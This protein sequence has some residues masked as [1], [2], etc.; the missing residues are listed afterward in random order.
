MLNN[1]DIQLKEKNNTK[2]NFKSVFE[3]SFINF[4]ID[5]MDSHEKFFMKNSRTLLWKV[6]G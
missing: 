6:N 1:E 3:K 5:H 2:D 4:V